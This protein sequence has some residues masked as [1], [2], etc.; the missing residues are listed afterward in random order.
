[1]NSSATFADQRIEWRKAYRQAFADASEVMPERTAR[2]VARA[3]AARAA[4]TTNGIQGGSK[5]SADPLRDRALTFP[6]VAAVQKVFV[7]NE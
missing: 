1:M 2:E 7:H 4:C 3:I 5:I 6:R